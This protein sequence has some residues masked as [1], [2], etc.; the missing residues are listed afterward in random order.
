MLDVGEADVRVVGLVAAPKCPLRVKRD[1]IG[2]FV[3]VGVR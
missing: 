3:D 1:K 2:I